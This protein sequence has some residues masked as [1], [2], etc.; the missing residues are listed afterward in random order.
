MSAKGSVA[1][2]AVTSFTFLSKASIRE[3]L[4]KNLPITMFSRM[5]LMRATF[6][7]TSTHTRACIR[8]ANSRG[9][10]LMV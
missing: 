6:S 7:C 2:R 8:H 1:S 3:W 9:A 5:L 4:S 10:E